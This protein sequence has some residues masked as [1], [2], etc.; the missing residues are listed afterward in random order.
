VTIQN[1]LLKDLDKILK[2]YI[3]KKENR[4]LLIES[5]ASQLEKRK[6]LRYRLTDQYY[7]TL[8][9]DERK[10][11]SLR[12]YEGTPFTLLYNLESFSTSRGA[13]NKEL[14]EY[15]I[16][17]RAKYED[18]IHTLSEIGSRIHLVYYKSLI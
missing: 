6:F 11:K 13:W 10:I 8:T 7:I 5:I 4:I 16:K 3:L 14:I 17:T 1:Y 12:K 18:E 9:K 15:G 2:N